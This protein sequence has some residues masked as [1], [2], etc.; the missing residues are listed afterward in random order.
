VS[1]SNSCQDAK[2]I[3]LLDKALHSYALPLM[4]V[5]VVIWLVAFVTWFRD[6]KK[7][8]PF[9]GPVYDVSPLFLKSLLAFAAIICVLLAGSQAVV[10]AARKEVWPILQGRN[11]QVKVR[12]N[13]HVNLDDLKNALAKIAEGSAHHSH[14]T[15]SYCVELTS[16]HQSLRLV[17]KRDSQN[18]HEYWVFYPKYYA[19]KLNEVGRV[20][21]GALDGAMPVK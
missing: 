14:P 7:R 1:V 15:T 18:L 4:G 19:T 12:A 9:T 6:R 8:G 17:L 16:D 20:F 3:I 21:T 11:Y 5:A 2:V 13:G 10:I